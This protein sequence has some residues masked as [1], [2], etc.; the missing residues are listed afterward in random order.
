VPTARIEAI[1]ALPDSA[2]SASLQVFL[3][4]ARPVPGAGAMGTGRREP[5]GRYIFSGVTPGSYTLLARAAP[6]GAAPAP[7]VGRGRGA[8][9]PLSF[10]ASVELVVEGRDLSVPLEIKSGMTV[11]GR[12]VFRGDSINTP[13]DGVVSIGLS[14]ARESPALGVP[15]ASADAGGAFRFAGVP[16]GPYRVVHAPGTIGSFILASATSG[17]RDLLDGVLEIRAGEDVE[18]LV[19]TFS[20]RPSELTGRLVTVAGRAA[21][22]YYILAF[23]A[24]RAFWTPLSRRVRPVRPSTDGRFSLRGLPS[25]E[26]FVAALTDVEP[27][28]WYDPAFLTNLIPGAVKVTLREGEATVQDLRIK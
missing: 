22:D 2:S 3:V 9:P 4:P 21:P 20:D 24:D 13:K 27:G 7:P 26:Y 19:V 16:P 8:A 14:P 5:D 28:E 23:A 6:A 11:S 1:P 17:G 15:S 12:V 18:D 10:Y 25:G